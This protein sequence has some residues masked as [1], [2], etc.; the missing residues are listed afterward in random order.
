MAE[1]YKTD[2]DRQAERSIQ[3]TAEERKG[4]RACESHLFVIQELTKHIAELKAQIHAW[5]V[6]STSPA[7]EIE[8]KVRGELA[9]SLSRA[10]GF[11]E[12]KYNELASLARKSGLEFDWV[13]WDDPEKSGEWEFGIDAS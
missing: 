10:K 4:C 9:D 11:R 8:R 5:Q 13:D 7:A 6:P 1:D 12:Q 3:F 2:G